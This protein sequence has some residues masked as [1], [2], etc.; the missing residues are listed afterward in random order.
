MT[1]QPT[2]GTVV[3]LGE[4]LVRFQTPSGRRLESGGPLD[5][6][7]GGAELNVLV[8]LARLGVTA[9]WVT[10]L[11]T[12]P[13]GRLVAAHAQ[14]HAVELAADWDDDG[15]MGLYFYE[16][17]PP[18][19]VASVTYDRTNTAATAMTPQTTDWDTVLDEAGVIHTTGITLA[20]SEGARGTALRALKEGRNRGAATTFDI[21]HRASLWD[22]GTARRCIREALDLTDIVFASH[23]D[24]TGL[25]GLGSDPIEAAR[26]LRERHGVQTVVIPSRRTEPDG[27]EIIG[28][29]V[30]TDE[31]AHGHEVGA[32]V[33][34][35]IGT[36]DAV[37][38][39]FIASWLAGDDDVTSADKAATAGA[40]KC[41][42]SGDALLADPGDLEITPRADR[43]VER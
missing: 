14:R 15:R 24:L 6:V 2:A 35:P 30:V 19:R 25:L 17:A 18:P 42:M 34:D 8:L 39:A 10:R 27:R 9:R 23:H 4:G 32:H 37:C 43:R 3:G 41:A 36:G 40:L 31:V 26:S 21:N 1:V 20:I 5:V 28:V 16:P 11:P 33:V 12:N 7:V 13:L 22:P 38:G 29:T